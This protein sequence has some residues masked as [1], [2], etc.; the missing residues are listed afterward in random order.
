[1][2][3]FDNEQDQ[4]DET[5]HYERKLKDTFKPPEKLIALQIGIFLVHLG[6]IY[7]DLHAGLKTVPAGEIPDICLACK[8][9]FDG[10]IE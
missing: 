8:N 1:M 5:K 3:E 10:E 6:L 7:A 4:P 2:H 9:P